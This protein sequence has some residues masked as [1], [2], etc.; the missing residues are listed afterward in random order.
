MN[1]PHHHK[2]HSKSKDILRIREQHSGA[3]A[4]AKLELLF[5]PKPSTRPK[6]A[7][8]ERVDARLEEMRRRNRPRDQVPCTQTN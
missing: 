5:A 6:G 4:E 3:A 2:Q 1:H 7:L 8:R